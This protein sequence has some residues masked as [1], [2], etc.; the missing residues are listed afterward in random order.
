MP[1]DQPKNANRNQGAHNDVTMFP[2]KSTE[3]ERTTLA[4]STRPPRAVE[5]DLEF[6]FNLAECKLG[7]SCNVYES[8]NHY[9]VAAA[10]SPDAVVEEA[11]RYRLVRRALKAIPDSDAGVLQVAYEVRPWPEA[12][13]RELGR[14]TGVVV[15]LTCIPAWW[16]EEREAQVRMDTAQADMLAMQLRCAGHGSLARLRH[17]AEVRLARAHRL[18]AAARGR[19]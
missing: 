13:T 7:L 9:G 4:L 5:D 11:H 16:P 17:T 8:L 14:L 2:P 18:Y 10:P 1:K 15:R 6:Y 3:S 19:P 12:L